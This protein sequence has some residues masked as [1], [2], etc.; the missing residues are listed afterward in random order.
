M[1]EQLKLFFQLDLVLICGLPSSGKSSFAREHFQNTSFFRLN[2][3][4]IRRMIF[5]M[6]NFGKTWSEDEFNNVDEAL[7]KYTEKRILE[8]WLSVKRKVLID[9]TSVTPAS[10][11]AYIKIAGQHKLSIGAIYIN[12]SPELCQKRNQQSGKDIIPAQVITGMAASAAKPALSEGFSEVFSVDI[13]G[14]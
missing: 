14:T 10:R 11:K 1:Q 13:N 2:R 6:A 4:E 5:E 7:V 8:H 9:N 3:K 12:A